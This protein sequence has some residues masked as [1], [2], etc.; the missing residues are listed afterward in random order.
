MHPGSFS[1]SLTSGTASVSSDFYTDEEGM[2]KHKSGKCMVILTSMWDCFGW[3]NTEHMTITFL[4]IQK[5][6]NLSITNWPKGEAYELTKAVRNRRS[7]G[8]VKHT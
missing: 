3:V 6:C 1:L 4:G 2:Q 7:N 5:T 8:G